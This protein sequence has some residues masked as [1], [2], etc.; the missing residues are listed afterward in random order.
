[1][2]V[3]WRLRGPAAPLALLAA[4]A[5]L[6][7]A[8]GSSGSSS[9]SSSSSSGSSGSSDSSGKTGGT[10]TVLMGTA[11]DYLD[12]QRAYTTQAAEA[13]WISYIGLYTYAHKAGTDGGKVIP[14]IAQDFPKVSNG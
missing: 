8:C 6:V 7:A 2:M 14:G 5:M 13:H 1:M 12:P 11:P 4:L 3:H 9:S 10:A